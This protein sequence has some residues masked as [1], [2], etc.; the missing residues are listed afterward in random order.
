MLCKGI[1]PPPCKPV[2]EDLGALA[3]AKSTYCSS[4]QNVESQTTNALYGWEAEVLLI[5]F[6]S[7]KPT[8]WAGTWG[9]LSGS[10]WR[11]FSG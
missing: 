3:F 4:F 7:V 2:F 5:L 11:C 9:S 1:R 8:D 6:P 10:L